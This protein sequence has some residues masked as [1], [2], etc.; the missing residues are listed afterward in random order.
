VAVTVTRVSVVDRMVSKEYVQTARPFDRDLA[1]LGAWIE[2]GF[3]SRGPSA[4]GSNCL[5][6]N[7]GRVTGTG[8]LARPH[9]SF[10]EKN[11]RALTSELA[12]DVVMLQDRS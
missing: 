4:G 5:F 11:M 9:A 2:T 3:S 10:V 1:T 8:L 7:F 6:E 12:C